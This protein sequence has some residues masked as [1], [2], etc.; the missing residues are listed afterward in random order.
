MELS[1]RNI[2]RID[3]LFQFCQLYI[4]YR[5]FILHK[6]VARSKPL[7]YESAE[8]LSDFLNK[9]IDFKESKPID[10]ISD[11]DTNSNNLIDSHLKLKKR[12]DLLKAVYGVKYRDSLYKLVKLF[13]R[14]KVYMYDLD[15]YF[16]MLIEGLWLYSIGAIS[17]L[18]FKK[19]YCYEISLFSGKISDI[20]IKKTIKIAQYIF[21]IKK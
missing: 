17:F 11:E 13:Y 7:T 5:D 10:F 16:S 2:D 3:Y 18:E 12:L 9:I 1:E 21:S 19:N 6:Q 8:S 15:T 14:K 4:V 20:N